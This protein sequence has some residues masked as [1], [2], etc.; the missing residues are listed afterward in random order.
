MKKVIFSISFICMSI[1]LSGCSIPIGDNVLHISTDGIEFEEKEGSSDV[2]EE[3]DAEEETDKEEN[4]DLGEEAEEDAESTT[5]TNDSTNKCDDDYSVI[6]DNLPPNTPIFDCAEITSVSQTDQYI[7][8]YYT[9]PGDWND[10]FNMYKDFLGDNLTEQQQS[11]QDGNANVKGLIDG[12]SI[13]FKM[14][15]KEQEVEVRVIHYFKE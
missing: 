5:S 4:I 13:E 14:Y 1:I 6:T 9:A 3:V 12:K 8:A 10:I 7:D 11:P 2:V 15:Q